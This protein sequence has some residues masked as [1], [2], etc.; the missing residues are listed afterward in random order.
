MRRFFFL[1]VELVLDSWELSLFSTGKKRELN[2]PKLDE[3]GNAGSV[4]GQ[5]KTKGNIKNQ[6]SCPKLT[7]L[8][9]KLSICFVFLSETF[10]PLW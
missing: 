4:A 6:K 8:K 7:S 10:V 1:N 2:L 5:E 9:P 3:K